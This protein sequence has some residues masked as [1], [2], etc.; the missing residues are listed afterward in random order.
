MVASYNTDGI[1]TNVNAFWNGLNGFTPGG[2]PTWVGDG[3]SSFIDY[4][5]GGTVPEP[6]PATN[7]CG[8]YDQVLSTDNIH[9]DA[10]D[11]LTPA[12]TPARLRFICEVSDDCMALFMS[13]Y[14]TA[15]FHNNEHGHVHYNAGG[16]LP[17]M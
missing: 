16:I 3:S 8:T 10:R 1:S 14:P 6:F 11:C 2:V 4:F 13:R 17:P 12:A 5:L 15:Y 9:M 7:F